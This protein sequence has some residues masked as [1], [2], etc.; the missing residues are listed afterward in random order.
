MRAIDADELIETCK[1]QLATLEVWAKESGLDTA[2]LRKG[3]SMTIDLLRSAE[4]LNVVARHEYDRTVNDYEFLVS[5]LKEE[6]PIAHVG[7]D[8]A[9][10]GYEK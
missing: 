7:Y 4:T 10:M 1:E 6:V 3:Y 9:Q 2:V 5:N 8:N